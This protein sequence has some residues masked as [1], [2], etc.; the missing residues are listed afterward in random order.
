MG[1]KKLK[2]IASRGTA[3]IQVANPDKYREL[4]KERFDWVNQSMLKMTL[5][6]YGTAAI[7]DMVNIKG[8]FPTRNWQTGQFEDWRRIDKSTTPMGWPK[9][10]RACAPYCL[11]PG[12]RDVEVKEGPYQGAHSDIEWETIYAFGSQCGVDK[13]E[14]IIAAGQICDEFGSDT[15]STGMTIGFAMECF[16]KG[17]IGSKDTDGVELRFGNDAAMVTMLQKIANQEGFGKELARGTKR[18][19]ELIKG[20][21]PFAMH[22]K[23]LE[24]GGYECRGFNGQALQFAISTVGGS[25]HAYGIPARQEIPDG[26]GLNVEGKGEYVKTGGRV[27]HFR[28]NRQFQDVDRA[29]PP[30]PPSRWLPLY[31]RFRY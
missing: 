28:C 12:C 5:E 25:H 22:A 8:G 7:L 24:L 14:A 11:T 2:A 20:S 26:S 27:G 6:V 18:L 21:E 23:G 17:L 10:N 30:D 29:D 15:M 31:L 16:E 9:N 3:K 13:M 1:S 19:S 4:A